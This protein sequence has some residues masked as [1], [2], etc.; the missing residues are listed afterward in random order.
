MLF[1]KGTEFYVRVD[2]IGYSA[3]R[4]KPEKSRIVFHKYSMPNGET[5]DMAGVPFTKKD[6]LIYTHKNTKKSKAL[7]YYDGTQKQNLINVAHQMAPLMDFDILKQKTIYILI[8]GDTVIPAD[9]Y[10]NF[11]TKESVLDEEL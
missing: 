4:S 5:Y 6:R 8:T 11:R 3:W 1:P 9:G 10:T 2:K 7:A